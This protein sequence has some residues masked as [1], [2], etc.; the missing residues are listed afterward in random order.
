MHNK[1]SVKLSG[2]VDSIKR[3]NKKIKEVSDGYR[4]ISQKKH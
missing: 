4:L 3:A 2:I 1:K